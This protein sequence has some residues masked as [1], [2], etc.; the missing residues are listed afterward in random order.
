MLITLIFGL[1]QVTQTANGWR[2]PSTGGR[3]NRDATITVTELSRA[4][5]EAAVTIGLGRIFA[6][7]HRGG[8]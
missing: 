8:R 1:R 2:A 6:L 3:F 5:T 4:E 7:H